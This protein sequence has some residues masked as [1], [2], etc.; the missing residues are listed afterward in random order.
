[1]PVPAPDERQSIINPPMSKGSNAPLFG[2]LTE[3]KLL[4]INF[5]HFLNSDLP[6]SDH[7]ACQ[8]GAASADA[9]RSAPAAAGGLNFQ[10]LTADTSQYQC[11]IDD[12][13]TV[14]WQR[15]SATIV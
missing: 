7:W 15:Y 9:A 8:S 5:E 2:G 12:Y 3:L 6:Q 10:L 4:S 1:M 11:S 14:W 13:R